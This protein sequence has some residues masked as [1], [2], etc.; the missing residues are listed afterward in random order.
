MIKI[1]IFI[2]LQVMFITNTKAKILSKDNVDIQYAD[3]VNIE[4]DVV[5]ISGDASISYN[6]ISIYADKISVN[7]INKEFNASGN[8][9]AKRL[10][11]VKKEIYI[12]ELNKL[13]ENK[14][15]KYNI[16]GTTTDK[17]GRTKYLVSIATIQDAWRGT[18]I[19]GNLKEKTFTLENFHMKAGGMFL[20]GE[21]AYR[22]TNGVITIKKARFSSCE[23][24]YDDHEHYAFV[25]NE[26]I[27]TPEDLRKLEL[28]RHSIYAKNMFLEVGKVPVFW[29][30]AF[31]KPSDPSSWRWSFQGGK[32]K[33]KGGGFVKLA[34][35]FEWLDNPYFGTKLLLDE[36]EQRGFG[37]GTK[38]KFYTNKSRTDLFLY[39]IRDRRPYFTEKDNTR[40]WLWA[41]K[42]D[43]RMETPKQRYE[44]D[45][46]H[47]N[48]LT[49]STD[50]RLQ[51]DKISDGDF[52]EDFSF[53]NNDN[54]A[55]FAALEQQFKYF[56][57]SIIV[58]PRVNEFYS[59]A[60]QTPEIRFD[61]PRQNITNFLYYQGE[62]SYSH[63]EMEWREY[64][65]IRTLG[66]LVDPSD[67]DVDRF[68]MLNMLYT[69]INIY[70]FNILPRAGV[71]NT[72]YTHSSATGLSTN[73]IGTMFIVDDSDRQWNGTI[74]NYDDDG[75]NLTRSIFELGIE[76]NTMFYKTSYDTKSSFLELDGV[77]HLVMPYINYNYI[78]EP[79]EDK[80]NIYYFDDIDRIEKQHFVRFGILQRF[81]TKRGDENNY[82][83]ANWLKIENYYDYHFIEDARNNH[84]GSFGTVIDFNPTEKLSFKT[85]L[86]LD[87]ES[88]HSH[89]TMTT[90]NGRERDERKG[91]S[92]KYIN[93]LTS[94]A[95][96]TII[97]DW[98]IHAGYNY[99]DDYIQRNI[100][101]MGSSLT[102]ITSGTSFLNS[103]SRSQT[104]TG[105]VSFPIGDKTTVKATETYDVE[106]GRFTTTTVLLNRNLHCWD[107]DIGYTRDN[108]RFEG[109]T[110][111]NDAVFFTLSLSAFSG[112]NI[113]ID[114]DYD[115]GDDETGWD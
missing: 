62:I 29:I 107:L 101:S 17:F 65:K 8:V 54:V 109:K 16:T 40:D 96:Y 88:V 89:D 6:G 79:D 20:V 64:D 67:F 22:D 39:R 80:E 95:Q 53:G 47:L 12:D 23:Y 81:Q 78:P 112:L 15:S 38:N 44:I 74:N 99:Q 35:R 31:Y 24:C 41:D 1:F 84:S 75:H 55:S 4:N 42:P 71:R 76:L 32:N 82:T 11:V 9:K 58:R 25:A 14:F 111:R 77:R 104:I 61:F 68:D 85:N 66:N 43:Y 33:D 97:D 59:V 50:F 113:T 93:A 18:L 91:I 49:N 103:Y 60:E 105:G 7:T 5:T 19:K 102:D 110:E 21:Q 28:G 57:S 92:S 34:K 70:D 72:H 37:Y 56:S 2:L 106:Q 30:P 13:K 27:L 86:L 36:Y 98:K 46:S 51:Y 63:F 26:V 83:V 48:H 114:R 3:K 115:T 73:D 90:R 69:P 52:K 87:L 10:D 108:Y 94:S 100:Y 45:F